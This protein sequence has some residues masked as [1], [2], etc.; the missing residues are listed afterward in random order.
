MK[1]IKDEKNSDQNEKIK[2]IVMKIIKMNLILMK[3]M[4]MNLELIKMY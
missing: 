4:K 3:M 2:L 1:I